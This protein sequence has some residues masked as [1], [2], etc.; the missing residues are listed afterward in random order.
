VTAPYVQTLRGTV[1]PVAAAS[2]ADQ[3]IGEAPFAGTV[4]GA[5][6]TPEAAITGNTAASRTL[7]IVNKGQAGAGSTVIGTL[8]YTTGVN[9]VAF[10]EQAFTLSAVAGATAIAEG[11]VLALV[12]TAVG[13]GLA[14]PGGL[15]QIECSR[16]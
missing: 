10:D 12:S 8:A 14:D 4:A 2:T 5:S 1:P 9:G 3:T 6:F 13:S 15:I 16:G 11:D 7:T